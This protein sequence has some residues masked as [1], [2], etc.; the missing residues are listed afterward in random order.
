VR[1]GSTSSDENAIVAEVY[2]AALERAGFRVD[3]HMRLGD[4]QDAMAA[5]QTAEIDLFPGKIQ[6]GTKPVVTGAL[7]LAASPANDS[8]CLLTSQYAAEQFWLLRLTK[9]ATIA[10]ELRLAATADFLAPGGALEQ[11]RQRY[12]GFQFKSVV[13]CAADEQ[14]YRLNLGDA[15]IANGITTDPNIAQTQLVVL[16]DDKHFWPQEHVAPLVRVATLRA[17]PHL[18]AVLDDLSPKLTLYTLQSLS[19]RAQ[20]FHMDPREAADDFVTSRLYEGS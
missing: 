1:V 4:A 17:H 7:W 2:S 8:P 9:C 20:T 13:S 18:A 14:L 16:S 19:S 15:D 5:L 3:R 12:G 10:H 6:A 11:L